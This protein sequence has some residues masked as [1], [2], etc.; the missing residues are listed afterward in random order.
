MLHGMGWEKGKAMRRNRNNKDAMIEPK[1]FIPRQALLGLWA[2]PTPQDLEEMRKK[3]KERE[4]KTNP[5][6]NI[7]LI[8]I[9]MEKW[10]ILKLKL[11]LSDEGEM[12][13]AGKMSFLN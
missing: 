13:W 9:V 8:L 1:Q 3:S 12:S 11:D 4:V 7:N 10:N 2:Q 5:Q 6:K